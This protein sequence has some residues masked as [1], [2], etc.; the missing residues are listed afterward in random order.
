MDENPSG[1]D[2]Y[3]TSLQLLLLLFLLRT[4]LAAHKGRSDL[5][6]IE[7]EIRFESNHQPPRERCDFN[8]GSR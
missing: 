6:L 8:R 1:S 2:L 4:R 3:T 5:E 7:I